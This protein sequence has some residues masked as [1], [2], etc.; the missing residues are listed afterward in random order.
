LIYQ[1]PANIVAGNNIIRRKFIMEPK[2]PK[3]SFGKG[4]LKDKTDI[5]F[6]TDYEPEENA[7]VELK[8]GK[9]VDVINGKYFNENVKL[10]VKGGRIEAMPGGEGQSADITADFVIDLQGKTVMPGLFNTHCHTTLTMPSLLPD[11]MDVRGFNAHAE[12][13]IESNMA[14]C[15]IHGITTIRDAWAADLRNVRSLRERIQRNELAGPRIMLSVAVGPPGGYLTE[16]HGLIMK[17][18][19]SMMGA[20]CLDYG[21]EHSGTVVF[22][23]NAAERHVRD[24]VNRAIDERGAEAIKIGEQKENTT[25]FKPDATIMTMDQLAAIAD[26]SSKRNLKS[27]IHHVSVASFRRA[28]NAGVSSLAHLAGDELLSED[29]IALFLSRNVIIEPTLSVL[30]DTSYKIKG[31]PAFDDSDLTLLT[32]FRNRVHDDI[33][34]AY[35][36]PELKAAARSH[37]GK[38]THGKMKMF[39]LL[40]MEKMFKNFAS[41]C[42]IGARNFKRLFLNGARMTTSNDG[43]VPPCTPAM[44]QH[45]VNLFNLF[46]NQGADEKIF[47][48]AD[49]VKMA[50]IIGAM[51]LGVEDDFGSIETGKVADLV[52]LDGD[53]FEDHRVVGSRVAA[54]FKDGRLIIN[55]CKLEVLAACVI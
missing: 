42:T 25:N 17:W 40:P 45:E 54:L 28:L 2:D 44:M 47:S 26:Q 50:T 36:I 11:I 4:N 32:Q 30:Y 1:L 3:S 34:E 53:P 24:A 8:N 33:V 51:C 22:A 43:G 19:R 13:Q 14:Q 20:P 37:H 39:G 29:D 52:I 10:V 49:A 55:N 27:T 31:D 7:Y 35:W 9:I 23:K 46:L 38:L 18:T 21:S 12:K 41:Y 5:N 48:G 16:K 15:L 6:I